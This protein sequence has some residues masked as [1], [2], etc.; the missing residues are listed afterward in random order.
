MITI[1]ETYLDIMNLSNSIRKSDTQY[2][3]R[4][5]FT[6]DDD[7]DDDDCL[8]TA[9]QKCQNQH[10]F[11]WITHIVVWNWYRIL[12]WSCEQSSLISMRIVLKNPVSQKVFLVVEG[13]T[14]LLK[15]LLRWFIHTILHLKYS[16]LSLNFVIWI[17]YI[18]ISWIL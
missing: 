6:H 14:Q 16:C 18:T 10:L 3:V 9:Q 1:A 12:V 8:K 5:E 17:H 13:G 15:K 2:N 4:W 7:D 11:I